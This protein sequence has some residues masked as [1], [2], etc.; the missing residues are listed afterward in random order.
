MT[1][2]DRREAFI[3]IDQRDQTTVRAAIL[4]RLSDENGTDTAIDS[5]VAACDTFRV[6]K[7]WTLAYPP[8]TEK[9]S[10]FHNVRRIALAEVEA[11]IAQRAVDV[12]IVNDWERLART[13]ERRY[14]ALYHARRFGVEY[15]FASL[16]ADGKLDDTPMAKL[17][18]R[19]MQV[20]GEMERD[21]I[22][23]RTMRGRMRRAERGVPTGGRG[24]APFGF[25]FVGEP[26]YQTWERNEQEAALLL[27][28]CDALMSGE[29]ASARSMARTLKARGI[30]TREG[31]DWTSATIS[32]KLRTR[33][34][35]GGV[36]C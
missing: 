21:K 23:A 7:G 14:Y 27:W 29:E 4:A 33:S 3:P 17:Y 8:F 6:R 15:R 32:A 20:F 13:E 34:T 19:V 18:G 35:A 31:H 5:Q 9:R 22:F 11:L 30:K 12:V 26:P 16:G 28:M 10:G 24:G 2:S 25:S 1:A 36:G